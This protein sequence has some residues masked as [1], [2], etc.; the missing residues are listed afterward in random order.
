MR[1][2]SANTLKSRWSYHSVDDIVGTRIDA[3]SVAVTSDN[4]DVEVGVPT[5]P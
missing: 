1:Q 5:D 2:D 3:G 4:G